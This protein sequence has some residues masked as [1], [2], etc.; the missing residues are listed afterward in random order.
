MVVKTAKVY[1]L[2]GPRDLHLDIDQ[3]P[4][5]SEG[6]LCKTIYSGISVGTELAAFL[7][8]SP[9]RKGSQYPRLQGYLNVS[10]VIDC[11]DKSNSIK[12]KRSL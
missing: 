3:I 7:G 1:R 9:L 2:Y 8:Y 6:F 12:N 11:I 4:N 5:D 10:Q